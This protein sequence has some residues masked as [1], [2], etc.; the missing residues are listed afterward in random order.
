[1]S[2]DIHPEAVELAV[3]SPRSPNASSP[4][5]IRVPSIPNTRKAACDLVLLPRPCRTARTPPLSV[6]ARA[7]LQG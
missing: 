7:V 3:V 4:V 6:P 1:M 2:I 5:F